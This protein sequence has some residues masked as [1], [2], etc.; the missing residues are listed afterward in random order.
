VTDVVDELIAQPP[1]VHGD[2]AVGEER[3][4][5]GL[6]TPAL[7][8]LAATVE[9]GHRT[10][11]TGS[12]YSTI[13]FA[14][15]GS[16]HTVVVPN[17]FEGGRIREYCASVGIDDSRV[18]FHFEPSE[19]VLPRL[20]PDPLDVVLIDGSHSFPHTFIDWFYTAHRLNVGGWMLIDDIHLWT[21]RVL[22]DFLVKDP[23]WDRETEFLGR[24]AL[25][26]KVTAT[27]PDV[28][29]TDQPVVVRRSGLQTRARV[30]QA[31]SMLR[32]GQRDELA[33]LVRRTLGRG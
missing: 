22:R 31:A 32:Y 27:D 21:G 3:M 10:L 20:A 6:S 15:A 19:R 9:S 14:S 2:E 28:L 17:E 18:S 24:T 1:A 16:E 29:W 12:G 8:F 5:H 26:R 7:R 4:T 23:A 30:Q 25:F 13:V 11:E 33:G